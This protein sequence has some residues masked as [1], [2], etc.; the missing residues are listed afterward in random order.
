MKTGHY[1]VG[2]REDGRIC[3]MWIQTAPREAAF[4]TGKIYPSMEQARADVAQLNEGGSRAPR[5]LLPAGSL[6]REIASAHGDEACDHIEK[7]DL[8]AA[9]KAARLAAHVAL[10]V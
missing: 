5:E 2:T 9:Y 1:E 7:G 10:D 4:W 8:D 3:Q 6:A